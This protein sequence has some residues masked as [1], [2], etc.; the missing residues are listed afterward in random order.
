MA[1]T[2]TVG[3]RRTGLGS[4]AFALDQSNGTF[5]ESGRML[6]KGFNPKNPHVGDAI[7]ATFFWVG[8]TNII[9]SVTDVL[10]TSPYTRVGNQYTLVEYVTA[11][12]IS[13]ATYAAF[14][15]QNF[16]D[17]STRD[18]HILA[19]R[20][21]L[22]D[23]VTGGI[24][25]TAYTGVASVTAQGMGPHRSASGTG[26]ST[27]IA[28][29]GAIAV[30][31]GAHVY[32][33]SLVNVLVGRDP[34]ADFRSFGTGS[35]ASIKGDGAYAIV[36]SAGTSDPQWT[37][38]FNS[39]STWIASV[40]ALNPA[41]PPQPIALDQSNGTFGES[42]R[43]L[44][45]G[46]NPTNPHVGDAIVATFYWV[47][48]T[49][50]ID[51]VTDHISSVDYPRVGNTYK[52]VQYT[53]SG[54]I[55]MATYVATNVQNFHDGSTSD[56]SILVVRANLS[57]SVTGGLAIAAYSGVAATFLHALG[58]QSDASGSG[59]GTTVAEPGAIAVDAGDLA[60][61]AS[62]VNALVGRDFP[63]GFT[64]FGTG[65]D[66]SIKGDGAYAVQANAGT[67]NPP[68]TWY[69]NAPSMWLASVLALRGQ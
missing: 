44:I 49:N 39:P 65:S 50:I 54:G 53:T 23:S 36:G 60:Y 18:D 2:E 42:G 35:D 7:I 3:P 62:L 12:G 5:G 43:V 68:W 61:T 41:P 26:S 15:V 24:M 19:V 63:P 47:G 45:K 21:D 25:I 37:W 55:S 33:A 16:P 1:C 32:T 30:N 4:P 34:P 17:T 67:I 20:A 9:D 29:A 57:D 59:S 48:S 58:A 56:D 11:G 51:S 13:M 8:S 27:T 40:L 64:S 38:Y 14:N 6:I 46:F 66:N 28:D 10:T 69:F 31:A 52:L 22:S